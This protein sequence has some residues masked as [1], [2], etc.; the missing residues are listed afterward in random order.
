ML[1]EDGDGRTGSWAMHRL[2]CNH[3]FTILGQVAKVKASLVVPCTRAGNELPKKIC[4][5]RMENKF[6]LE[7]SF[8]CCKCK[9]LPSKSSRTE[10]GDSMI[11]RRNT[12][13]SA[14]A[15]FTFD[16]NFI[17][18]GDEELNIV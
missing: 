10:A 4:L 18:E 2:I 13:A 16:W 6:V 14:N 17:N 7:T 15:A 1:W 9:L 8:V 3:I 12:L 5:E 11:H